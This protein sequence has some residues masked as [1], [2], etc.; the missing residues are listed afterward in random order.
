M[1]TTTT[2]NELLFQRYCAVENDAPEPPCF[3]GLPLQNPNI[4]PS[5]RFNAT[6]GPMPPCT[7]CGR[8]RK[9]HTSSHFNLIECQVV[10]HL[11]DFSVLRQ[12]A[13][14][15]PQ[16]IPSCGVT[17]MTEKGRI[18]DNSSG[19]YGIKSARFGAGGLFGDANKVL[20]IRP[21]KGECQPCSRVKNSIGTWSRTASI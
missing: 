12:N 16:T 9:C 10:S 8:S 1:F 2:G 17:S 6:L 11:V 15:S 19:R 14:K 13:G 4:P 21:K 18:L 20:T 7:G 3:V 5:N